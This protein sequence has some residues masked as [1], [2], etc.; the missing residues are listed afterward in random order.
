MPFYILAIKFLSDAYNR[1]KTESSFEVNGAHF[2]VLP[3]ARHYYFCYTQ[4]VKHIIEMPINIM[5]K[6]RRT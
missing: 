5:E 2:Q 6:G 3:I 4:Q 1:Q